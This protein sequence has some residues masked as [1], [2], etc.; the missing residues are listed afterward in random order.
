MDVFIL[1]AVCTLACATDLDAPDKTLAYVSKRMFD[2]MDFIMANDDF[3]ITD[4]PGAWF[5]RVSEMT[6]DHPGGVK[7]VKM[8][9]PNGSERFDCD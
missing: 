2:V 5:W 6:M 3:I 7:S 4:E 1:E 8:F 9:W